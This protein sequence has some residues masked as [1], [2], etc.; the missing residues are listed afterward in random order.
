LAKEQRELIQKF[1]S[2][3]KNVKGTVGST[4][5]DGTNENNDEK[6]NKEGFK[7]SKIF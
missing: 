1:A 7:W 2:M 4:D 6:E 3:E 5:P